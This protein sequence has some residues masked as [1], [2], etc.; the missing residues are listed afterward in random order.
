MVA[1]SYK[2]NIAQKKVGEE[3]TS[4]PTYSTEL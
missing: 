3:I 2:K 1:V 4:K